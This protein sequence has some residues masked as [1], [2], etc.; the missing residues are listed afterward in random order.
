[1]YPAALRLDAIPSPPDV[2]RSPRSLRRGSSCSP[3]SPC[4]T[5][6]LT[7]LKHALSLH[8]V[9]VPLNLPDPSVIRAGARDNEKAQ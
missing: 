5:Y 3:C 7:D 4:Y 1:M 8:I 2:T 6:T 9:P